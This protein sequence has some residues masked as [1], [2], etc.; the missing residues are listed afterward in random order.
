ME[1]EHYLEFFLTYLL[2]EK[3]AS[4]NTFIA[5]KSDIEQL[6]SFFKEINIT[7]ETY[8]L[9]HLQQ[10]LHV[11]RNK[12]LSAETIARKIS[13][14]K[15]FFLILYERYEIT[16]YAK[17]L[18]IPQLSKRLP[19]YLSEIE[20]VNLFHIAQQEA[21]MLRG[22]RNYV[23]LCVLY[24]S[25]MRVSELVNITIEQCD[26]LHGFIKVKGKRNKE[27]MIPLPQSIF[28]LIKEYLVLVPTTLEGKQALFPA[29]FSSGRPLTRQSCW[30]IIKALMKKSKIIKRISPHSFRHSLATHLLQNGFDLRSLQLI[31]GHAHVAT[32]QIY[33]HLNS[34]ELKLIYNRKHPRA[35]L[36]SRDNTKKNAEDPERD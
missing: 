32:V 3:R 2:A 20:I 6:I 23:M 7:L 28:M 26:F 31:L 15:L 30:I 34:K 9:T 25:G 19:L 36:N 12:K 24:S 1:D 16:D 22:M 8:S 33:T 11:L 4:S 35:G 10:Y 13:S 29:H 27:R 14:M 21:L 18:I 17:R 5:Y